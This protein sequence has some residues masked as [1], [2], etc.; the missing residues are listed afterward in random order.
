[1]TRKKALVVRG[2]WEGHQPVKAT[3]LFLPFLHDNGYVVRIEESTEVYADAAEMAG[4]D[5]VVQCVTMSEI[6]REQL[7]GLRAAV[8]TG[9]GFTGWHGGIADSFR[10][11]SDYL[12][13]VGGQ[14]ATH[15]GKEPCER[16]GG[17]EDNF[18]PAHHRHHRTRSRTP[19][20]RGHRGLRTRHR[21]VL[22]PP[23]RPDRRPGHHH[24]P[25]PAVA[26]LA[27][28]GHLAGDLDPPVGRRAHRGD[29][30]GAQPRRAREPQRPHRHREGHA[31]GDAHRIGV[32]GLGVIS[33]AYLDTLLGHPA[34][35]ITA[36]ADLDASRS[37]AVA[38]ELSGVQALTVE[39]LL[40]SP[41]VDTVLNLTVPAAH[42][43]DR[44]RRHR[45]R[46]AR[47]R[48]EAPGRRPRGRPRRAGGRRPGGRRCGVCA[49]HRPGHRN[50]DGTGGRGGGPH[51]TPPVRLGRHGHPGTRT[52]ASAPRLLLH[53][54]RRPAA[55]H[56]A[57][58]TWRPWSICW[59]RCVP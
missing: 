9:T 5:L 6:A 25:R 45:P 28:A 42:A 11:S 2:G 43:G 23:R 13:L 36:V 8:E 47:L 3:E 46:E 39:E 48:R 49:G 12:Q 21:A 20:H 34:V 30:T 15:P 51:R 58:T 7:S 37:A 19:R 59:V 4:T 18:L 27:P 10:A 53:G 55:G 52:L 31:V 14:F 17:A 54:R 57:A 50:P 29:D 26:A 22:G 56:G 24:P 41:D 32:V 35:R 33:R 44:P 38:A 40:R 16:Q 1:M